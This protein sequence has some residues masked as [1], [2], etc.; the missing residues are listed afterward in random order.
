MCTTIGP[1]RRRVNFLSE[2]RRRKCNATK[3]TNHSCGSLLRCTYAVDS[4]QKYK[5]GL[6]LSDRRGALITSWSEAGLSGYAAGIVCEVPGNHVKK[7]SVSYAHTHTGSLVCVCLSCKED[8]KAA[9][10]FC[11]QSHLHSL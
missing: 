3:R 7:C 6:R 11:I 9:E 10:C 5:S 8:H 2:M 4:R 1:I